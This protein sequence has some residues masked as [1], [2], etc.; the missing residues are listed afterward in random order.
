MFS[1]EPVISS[2]SAFTATFSS[3]VKELTLLKGDII[4]Y[5]RVL[6]NIGNCYHSSTGVF[7]V[8][9]AGVY[10]MFTTMKLTNVLLALMRN[11]EI[12]VRLYTYSNDMAS[13]SVNMALSE[14]D[15]I[16]VQVQRGT[17]VGGIEPFSNVFTAILIK[18][19]HLKKK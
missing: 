2:F 8:K 9:T 4:K 5:S 1:G 16:W 12:L 13:Q 19:G 14:G 15:K 10:S 17:R 18:P 3:N 6:A 11:G 7:T